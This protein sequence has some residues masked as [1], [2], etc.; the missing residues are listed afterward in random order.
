MFTYTKPTTPG[1]YHVNRG[2]VV[3]GANYEAQYF[4]LNR[5]GILV[6]LQDQSVADY[7]DS[8]KFMPIDLEALNKI[9][10]DDVRLHEWPELEQ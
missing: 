8:W 1:W 4:Q 7:N 6:D 10:N 9:G 5:H 2:D 3:T